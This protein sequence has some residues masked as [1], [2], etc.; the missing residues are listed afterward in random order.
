[1]FK[2][3]I[4]AALLLMQTQTCFAQEAVAQDRQQVVYA[5]QFA[6]P[7]VYR[8]W[9]AEVEKCMK[10]QGDFDKILWTVTDSAWNQHTSVDTIGATRATFGLWHGLD[11]GRALIILNKQDWR[12]EFYVK[13][14]MVHDLLWRSGWQMPS[15]GKVGVA[16]SV[17]VRAA[18][19]AP[20][21]E[22]CAPTYVW[23]MRKLWSEQQGTTKQVS[24]PYRP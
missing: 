9:Y 4:V 10:Q 2:L 19:P 6:P 20:P 18:H 7:L 16:D 13:H 21:Y 14:E 12:N 11:K 15:D 3:L 24:N 8:Q 22:K 23:Q 5:N 1:M 17:N